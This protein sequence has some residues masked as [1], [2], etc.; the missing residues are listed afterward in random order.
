M[1]LEDCCVSGGLS[2]SGG[3]LCGRRIECVWRIV[4][5]PEDRHVVGGL[6]VDRVWSF[7]WRIECVSRI[8]VW[9]EDCCVAGRWSCVLAITKPTTQVQSGNC[10]HNTIDMYIACPVN[11]TDS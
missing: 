11:T 10:H 6:R 9:P 1:C 4:V 2:V 5:W 3:L 7:S 8:L